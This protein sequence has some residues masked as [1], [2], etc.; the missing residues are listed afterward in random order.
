MNDSTRKAWS[1]HEGNRDELVA[2][3]RDKLIEAVIHDD[4]QALAEAR[5]LDRQLG[6]QPQLRVITGDDAQEC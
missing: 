1:V 6:R 2:L 3:A 5:R 4:E